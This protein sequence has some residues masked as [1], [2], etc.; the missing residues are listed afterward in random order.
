[1]DYESI[2]QQAWP[3]WTI[4]KRLGSGTYGSVFQA[5][6]T[7]I[8]G[9]TWAAIKAVRIPQ[10]DEEIKALRVEGYSESQTTLYL[11]K[12]VKDFAAEV[13]LMDAVKG[14]T[15]IVSI[16]DHKIIPMPKLPA[17]Y[18]LIRMELLTPL[19][20]RVA[21]H[22]MDEVEIIRLGLDLCQALTV[23]RRKN[24]V[25]RDIKP[26]NIFV[27]ADGDYKLGDFGVARNMDRLT[28]GFTRTGTFNYMAPEVFNNTL[29]AT[30]IDAV[31][32]VDIYSLGMVLYTLANNGRMPFMPQNGTPTREDR[33]RA[34]SSRMRG[35]LPPAP[36]NASAELTE[37]IR[38]ACAFMPQDRYDTA[39]DMRQ[40][41]MAVKEKLE[42]GKAKGEGGKADA[43]DE[44]GAGRKLPGLFAM[45]GIFGR[46]MKGAS[47]A[48]AVE[49]AIKPANDDK[50]AKQP[51]GQGEASPRTGAFER[52]GAP[53]S[54]F[55]DDGTVD[56]LKAPTGGFDR[57]GASSSAFDRGK[58]STGGFDRGGAP[59]SAFDRGK[60]STGGFDR[61]RSGDEDSGKRRFSLPIILGL[62]AVAIA[63]IVG[64]SLAVTNWGK[65]DQPPV[66][67]PP[68]SV[69]VSPTPT[70]E[71]T[72]TPVPY[73]FE[74]PIIEEEAR[75]ALGASGTLSEEM[76]ASIASLT[77]KSRGLSDL[78]DLAGMT[79]L[80][81]LDLRDNAIADLTP[82]QSLP[83][84][85]E[86]YLSDNSLEDVS[87]LGQ[88]Q[89]LKTLDL[90]NNAIRDVS[91]LAALQHL[92]NLNLLD[93]LVSDYEPV[94]FV[95]NLLG[96]ES[97]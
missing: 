53:S 92:E 21:T 68:A 63:A 38:H 25:H 46:A 57:G 73:V 4:E 67:A 90:H 32:K 39:D 77:I 62:A 89:G 65:Y 66:T 10:S 17:W 37:V 59:S 28:T 33:S 22:T 56:R 44:G 76:V 61:G 11:E 97:E 18:I 91:P 15:N 82:L 43:S 1:M 83:R 40:A 47:S 85:E 48:P 2:I 12:V 42:G 60:A 45:S 72:P 55:D 71:P 5:K 6:R 49:S 24:I 88:L 13:R 41:L 52:G 36:V 35:E 64:I 27:N 84:L 7:D 74:S 19:P 30:D 95:Q 31:A 87:P 14:N 70:P 79:G 86:L 81:Y 34:I 9:T 80:V 50:E 78:T 26:A 8:V 58:A 16:E 93:N 94:A 69:Q 29:V 20:T 75:K 51:D 23:C 54:V 96:P 3:D